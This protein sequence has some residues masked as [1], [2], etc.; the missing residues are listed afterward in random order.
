MP[1]GHTQKGSAIVPGGGWQLALPFDLQPP[2]GRGLLIFP[3]ACLNG[4]RSSETERAQLGSW[5]ASPSHVC[6]HLALP[7][8]ACRAGPA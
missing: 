8:V 7:V 3:E 5:R 2:L 4:R 1:C 6:S